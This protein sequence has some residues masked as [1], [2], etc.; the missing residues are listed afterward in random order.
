MHNQIFVIEFSALQTE[1]RIRIFH[2]IL[3][4]YIRT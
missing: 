2:D 1:T 4:N 3:M